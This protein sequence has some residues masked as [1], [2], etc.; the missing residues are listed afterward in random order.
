MERARLPTL[1][2]RLILQHK[3]HLDD[4]RQ[5]RRHQR[6]PKRRVHHR[7][8][9]TMLR[10]RRHAPPGQEQHKPGH[11]I[12]LRS[13]IPSAREPHARQPRRP[14]DH[15]H[16]GMLDIVLNPGPPPPVLG[17]GIDAAPRG[18]HRAVEELLAAPRAAQPR[19]PDEEHDHHEGT[20]G[21]K[22]RPHDEVREALP[23]MVIATIPQRG[24]ATEQHLHPGGDGHGLAEDAVGEDRAAAQP[25]VDALLEVQLEVHAEHGLHEQHEHEPVGE[26]GV[27]V[28]GELAALVR[29]A[30]E[31]ADDGEKAAE[32]L[33][34]DVP[35]VADDLGEGL[36]INSNQFQGELTP[37]TIP[38]GK[39]IPKETIIIIICI[40]RIA[41][42]HPSAQSHPHQLPPP[43]PPRPQRGQ[44]TNCSALVAPPSGISSSLCSCAI[45]IVAAAAI[46]APTI[47]PRFVLH[48]I[49]IGKRA[50]WPPMPGCVWAPS[51]S[52][53]ASSPSVS[54]LGNVW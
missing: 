2:R 29:V 17:E 1:R 21:N 43:P 30:H 51:Q 19:L 42:C 54:Q 28:R 22:R 9:H 8:Q 38:I 37:R 53:L 50:S 7:A 41:S 39:I 35:A 34:G 49:F 24:N 26:L 23:E 47:T 12:A 5:P 14:P 10:M 11:E 48:A 3:R 40:Q 33:H 52:A 32:D 27:H 36:D 20:V 15:T 6:I 44:L 16:S 46:S 4:P 31:V 45:A 25:A 18:D 13:P